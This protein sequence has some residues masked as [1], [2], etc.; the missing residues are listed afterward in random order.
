MTILLQVAGNGADVLVDGP[1]VVVQHHD[2]ALG[3]VRDV[4]QR[5]VGDPA[6]EG[7]ISR[8][9]DHMFLAAGLVAGHRHA[10]RRRER[11]AGVARAVAIVRAFRA[12][13]EPVQS[14]RSAYGVELLLAPGQQLV[15]IG[16][17][18]DVEQEAVGR[19]VERIVQGDGKFHHAQVRPKMPAV[20]GKNGDQPFPYF[21]GQLFEFGKGELLYLLG[22]MNTFEYVGHSQRVVCGS[23]PSLASRAQPA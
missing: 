10:E 5:F 15:H 13:H 3:V 4:V 19:R 11:R 8:H 16:L 9:R 22:G 1:L 17:V 21:G 2:Q 6:G 7:R 23:G 20:V 18:A 14:A 12:Q